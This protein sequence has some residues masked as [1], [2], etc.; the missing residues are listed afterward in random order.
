MYGVHPLSAADAH[1]IEVK[2]IQGATFVPIP[3]G[4]GP[5]FAGLFTVDLPRTVKTGQEFN[6]VV[7]RI[8][9]RLRRALPAPPPPQ[10]V[11]QIA[12]TKRRPGGNIDLPEPG[13]PLRAKELAFQAAS[14]NKLV[15]ERYIVGSFQVK[16]P[17]ST[18]K[19]MLPAEETTLAILKARLEA[20]P[21]TNPWH[22]V[23]VRYIHQVAGRVG[24]HAN[25]IPPSLGGYR[26]GTQHHEEKFETFTGKVC[27]VVFD[28]FG[29]FSGFVLEDCCE[30]RAFECGRREIGD[31]VLRA[32]RERLALMIVTVGK[33][34]KIVRLV[35]RG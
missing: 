5:G 17:V 22:P 32:L 15:Y 33:D 2:T 7:R 13:A 30:H 25:S 8:G 18:L 31:L 27:E 11:P 35:V 6:I 16:I 24:D 26:P 28:C 14:E 21:T 12:L 1:T 20:M 23:L 19:E 9:K 3:L 29:D 4:T 34:R 10:P